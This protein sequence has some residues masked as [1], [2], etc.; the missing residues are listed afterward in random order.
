MENLEEIEIAE[1]VLCNC[2]RE[3]VMMYPQLTFNVV[4]DTFSLTL[5]YMQSFLA[6]YTKCGTLCL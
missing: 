6:K 4:R 1:M 2:L 5:H 3:D